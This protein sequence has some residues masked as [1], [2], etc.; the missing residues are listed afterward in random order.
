MK[1]RRLPLKHPSPSAKFKIVE[2]ICCISSPAGVIAAPCTKH[3]VD[4]NPFVNAKNAV[5]I[6]GN[7]SLPNVHADALPDALQ[8]KN[9]GR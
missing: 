4:T 2:E 7:Q 6:N 3:R 8:S 1:D 9:K 5:K